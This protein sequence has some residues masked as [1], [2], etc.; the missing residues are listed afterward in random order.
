MPDRYD[1]RGNA[2]CFQLSEQ[3]FDD[4]LVI[5]RDE[6]LWKHRRIRIE[7]CP[8]AAGEYYGFH[9]APNMENTLR[10]F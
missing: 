1:D 6:R 4:R 7:S 5:D 2:V 9:L 3:Y 10:I 8:F